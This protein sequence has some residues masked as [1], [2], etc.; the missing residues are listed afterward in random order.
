MSKGL[1]H[2]P[3][4]LEYRMLRVSTG[5]V[6]GRRLRTPRGLLT[7]PTSGKVRKALF[8]ILGERIGDAVFLD[9]FSGTG[10]VGIEA[11]SRG[12]SRAVLVERDPAALSVLRRNVGDCGMSPQIEILPSDVDRMI[13]D[14]TAR[15]FRADIV[16]CD[17]PYAYR[18]MKKLLKRLGRGDIIRPTGVL[19][20]EHDRKSDPGE[21]IGTLRRHRRY[22]YGSTQLSVYHGQEQS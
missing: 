1:R 20:I 14:L 12:A 22:T 13:K 7:R 15:R 4:V 3:R 19:I 8:D 18:A 10:G 2:Y 9:L 11:V 17:P 6:R 5:S 16:Y 21:L